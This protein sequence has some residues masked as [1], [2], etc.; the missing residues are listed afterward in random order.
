MDV[1]TVI[2]KSGRYCQSDR[3]LTNET[4]RNDDDLAA[5]LASV[6]G[7]VLLAVRDSGLFADRELGNAGDSVSQQVLSQAL[8]VQRP[9]DSVLSEE[10]AEDPRRLDAQR[11]W[12]IDP[13]D[14]TREYGEGRND[15]A[16]HV[17]LAVDGAVGPSAVALPGLDR[18]MSSAEPLAPVDRTDG[19]VRIAVS[20]S[21]APALA[22][23]VARRVDAE[24]VP[25]GSAGFKGM[26][27]LGGEVD[28]Y[29]HAGGQYEW[30]SA[31]PVGVALAN[32]L[33][34]SRIDGSTLAYNRPDPLL[35]DLLI[36]RRELADDLLAAV[37][38]ENTA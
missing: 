5:R 31:A 12:I 33:H 16:V 36:C 4:T 32:G 28:A 7:Q 20:R 13:L 15:W 1:V 34:A 19:R 10:G 17:A 18:V 11:V 14:G 27:V 23:G 30:D 22:E 25:M 26:A 35:P 37:E 9:D 29:L 21:R 2:D 3:G 8:A 38:A 6:A 24:L